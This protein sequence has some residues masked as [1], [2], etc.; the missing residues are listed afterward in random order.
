[1][2]FFDRKKVLG[3]VMC[4]GKSSRMGRDKGLIRIG[5]KTWVE[6]AEEKFNGLCNQVVYSIHASQWNAYQEHLP[7]KIYCIDSLP[8]SGPLAGI[9]SVYLKFPLC[10]LLV[11]ACDL[12]DL[13]LET[14]ARLL[15]EAAEHDGHAEFFIYIT[16]K[17]LEPLCGLYLN[18]GLAKIHHWYKTGQVKKYSLR[19]LLS[20]CEI[21]K[22]SVAPKISGEFKNFNEPQDLS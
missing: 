10:H 13:R 19:R 5:N 22:I 11:L 12:V 15:V 20:R 6:A 14:L 18:H 8:F 2:Q 9:L 1:M 16:A 21:K 7:G 4:G 17:F 3:V